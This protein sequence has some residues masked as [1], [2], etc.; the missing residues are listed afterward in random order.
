M[1][2][3]ENVRDYE[4]RIALLIEYSSCPQPSESAAGWE[5][6]LASAQDY[7]KEKVEG[8]KDDLNN[9]LVFVS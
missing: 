1:A 6:L 4:L 7:D 8:W 3:A 9:L 2:P 5:F